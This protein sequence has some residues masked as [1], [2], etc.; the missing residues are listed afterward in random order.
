M[1]GQALR[2]FTPQCYR[3]SCFCLAD[4]GWEKKA[5]LFYGPPGIGKTTTANIVCRACG[6]EVCRCKTRVKALVKEWLCT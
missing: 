6:Y 4:D 5:V 1:D 2:L 3:L